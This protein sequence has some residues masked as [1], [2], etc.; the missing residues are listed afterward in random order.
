MQPTTLLRFSLLHE[1][2]QYACSDINKSNKL[3]K[4]L[5]RQWTEKSN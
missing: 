5:G 1:N 2:V 3:I 4:L